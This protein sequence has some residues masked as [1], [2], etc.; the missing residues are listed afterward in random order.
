MKHCPEEKLVLLMNSRLSG[1]AKWQTERHV[2]TCMACQKHLAEL[3]SLSESLLIAT[4]KVPSTLLTA[5]LEQAQSQPIQ[6]PKAPSPLRSWL[7]APVIGMLMGLCL[8]LW[9]IT[10]FPVSKAVSMRVA[11][12]STPEMTTQKVINEI[13]HLRPNVTSEVS[14]WNSHSKISKN[15]WVNLQVR[16][17]KQ[18]PQKTLFQWV[19]RIRK[20]P[21]LKQSN[22]QL[23]VETLP[24][25]TKATA[26]APTVALPIGAALGLLLGALLG[27]FLWLIKNVRGRLLLPFATAFLGL[28]VS[29][30][31]TLRAGPQI[32][33]STTIQLMALRH[34]LPF[35]LA[36]NEVELLLKI[37][38][39][40]HNAKNIKQLY[41]QT[42]S[43][44]YSLTEEHIT[45]ALVAVGHDRATLKTTLAQWTETITQGREMQRSGWSPSILTSIEEQPTPLYLATIAVPLLLGLL[46]GFFFGLLILFVMWIGNLLP[47]GLVGCIVIGL[48][49]GLACGV[50]PTISK[51]GKPQVQSAHVEVSFYEPG[52]AL[53]PQ[54]RETLINGLMP[55]S[56]GIKS[57][58]E[59]VSIGSGIRESANAHYQLYG[60]STNINEVEKFVKDW[61]TEVQRSRLTRLLGCG[62]S[63]GDTSVNQSI[64]TNS[65]LFADVFYGSLIGLGL[66]FFMGLTRRR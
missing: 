25:T 64:H 13:S 42:E 20:S 44:G 41:L 48:T 49:L 4:T 33:L 61:A 30:I 15:H 56:G 18:D 50:F 63:V 32:K 53:T 54:M 23:W 14:S 37:I 45:Y 21:K 31:P 52:K 8:T 9:L 57:P 3:T 16:D 5:R 12:Q 39:P 60:R 55:A 26:V 35:T 17:Q 34:N 24:R 59:P 28:I 7:P 47:G 66:G 43:S 62:V 38:K 40:N 58:K 27:C 22:I 11:F 10:A 19:D 46:G 36:H 65:L 1:F 2:K 51:L 29:P 6:P